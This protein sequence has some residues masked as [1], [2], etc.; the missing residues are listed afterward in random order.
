MYTSNNDEASTISTFKLGSVEL[1]FGVPEIQV[2]YNLVGS[3]HDTLSD[4]I[5][6]SN[7]DTST[8][9]ELEIRGSAYTS[10]LVFKMVSFDNVT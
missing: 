2:S 6:L 1:Q 5:N 7:L 4:A 3:E 10:I 9:Y 8:F